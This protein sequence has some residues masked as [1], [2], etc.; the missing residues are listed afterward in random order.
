M[1]LRDASRGRNRIRSA[2][3]VP[4]NRLY[5]SDEGDA[6]APDGYCR[7]LTAI[8]RST[9]FKRFDAKDQQK[10]I[11]SLRA[12]TSFEFR[13]GEPWNA[14]LSENDDAGERRIRALL[15]S[16]DCKTDK[17]ALDG[18]IDVSHYSATYL[19]A[20][21]VNLRQF[22][23]ALCRARL[24]APDSPMDVKN[25]RRM[26]ISERLR[27]A[28]ARNYHPIYGMEHAGHRFF[29]SDTAS[30]PRML[31]NPYLAA[32][33][34]SD[35]VDNVGA[36]GLIIELKEIGRINGLR[37]SDYAFA[38]AY[39]YALA[40]LE[41]HFRCRNKQSRGKLSKS[42]AMP[43]AMQAAVRGR[44]A[45]IPH[46]HD[47]ERTLWD[48]VVELSRR[49]ALGGSAAEEAKTELERYFLFGRTE[50]RDPYGYDAYRYWLRKAALRFDVIVQTSQGPWIPTSIVFRKAA[51]GG[52]V[53]KLFESTSDEEKRKE[54]L[55]AIA[56][57]FGHS[58]DQTKVY[59]DWEYEQDAIRKRLRN[60]EL[61]EQEIDAERAESSARRI[62]PELT[63]TTRAWLGKLAAR[64]QRKQLEK[65]S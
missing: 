35:A 39:G 24:H 30:D 47:A 64:K 44:F 19:R 61:T 56:E 42:A 25:W 58:T 6:V 16:L 55:L 29:A 17:I 52:E 21:L 49:L 45:A 43:S 50:C 60:A 32:Q 62:S 48:R 59:A 14:F 41:D 23:R 2:D 31:Y 26:G 15:N 13:R 28:H 18:T 27:W 37:F 54:G 4:V 10:A 53:K 22:Y 33:A 36:P 5:I 46:P 7:E 3:R 65:A 11:R 38:T 34:I 51:I 9:V 57:K 8:I 12:L 20:L 63:A 40:G 1:I